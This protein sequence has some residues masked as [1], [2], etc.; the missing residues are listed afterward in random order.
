MQLK[1]TNN[2]QGKRKRKV[3]IQIINKIKI[4]KTL[5]GISNTFTNAK[6]SKFNII[7]FENT[8]L[9]VYFHYSVNQSSKM[10]CDVIP[11]IRFLRFF[12]RALNTQVSIVSV[13]S[14]P[15][16]YKD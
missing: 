2:G 8:T 10:S 5:L 11:G 16:G 15:K 6:I 14:N 12:K 7:K 4:K 3:E 13:K 1:T 9:W